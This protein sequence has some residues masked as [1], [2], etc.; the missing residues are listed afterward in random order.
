MVTIIQHS[1]LQEVAW[2]AEQACAIALR[3][4]RLQYDFLQD[5]HCIGKYTWAV[6]MRARAAR[7]MSASIPR[8]EAMFRAFDLPGMPHIRRYV[9]ASLA[10][11][12][13][14]L[15]FSNRSS[16][17]FRDVSELHM[18]HCAFIPL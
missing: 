12:N 8:R 1:M 2:D 7:M 18:Q 11:S 3:A 6:P 10:S 14:M 13:S 17:Y 16:W 5:V 4:I 15:A 9:G